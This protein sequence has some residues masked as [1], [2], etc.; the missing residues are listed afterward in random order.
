MIIP[1]PIDVNVDIVDLKEKHMIIY[2]SSAMNAETND[3]LRQLIIVSYVRDQMIL[4]KK[5]AFINDHLDGRLFQT[6]G[7]RR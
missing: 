5:E 2:S 7:G 3:V 6:A 1:S 4:G